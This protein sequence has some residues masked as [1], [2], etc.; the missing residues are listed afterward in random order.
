MTIQKDPAFPDTTLVQASLSHA[1]ETA[2]A[3]SMRLDALEALAE[4]ESGMAPSSETPDN[5]QKP[6]SPTPATF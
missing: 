6:L 1:L 5:Q 2:A 4:M 3:L